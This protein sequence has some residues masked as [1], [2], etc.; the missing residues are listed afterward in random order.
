MMTIMG[1]KLSCRLGF[2]EALLP[3]ALWKS[4]AFFAG[5]LLAD[6]ADGAN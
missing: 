1:D 2:V 5:A 6:W 3:V 4:S